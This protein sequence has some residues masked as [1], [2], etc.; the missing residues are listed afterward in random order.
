MARGRKEQGQV[1]TDGVSIQWILSDPAFE[2][3]VRDIRAGRLFPGDFDD[4]DTNTQWNYERGRAFAKLVPRSVALKRE[5]RL[6]EEAVSWF[7]RVGR[8]FL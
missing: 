6:T 1:P 3:G 5:G 8:A 2:R 7:A 4:W